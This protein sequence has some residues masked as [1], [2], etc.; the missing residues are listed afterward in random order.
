MFTLTGP[1]DSGPRLFLRARDSS[2]PRDQG[3]RLF[4]AR[5]SGPGFL[6]A[7][8]VPGSGARREKKKKEELKDT[9]LTNENDMG[10]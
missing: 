10:F 9:R 6:G 8:D 4:R 3:P 5:D 2:R 1:R 7:A